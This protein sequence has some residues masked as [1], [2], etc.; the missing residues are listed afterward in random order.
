MQ[1]RTKWR[2]RSF[3]TLGVWTVVLLLQ[4]LLTWP[5]HAAEKADETLAVDQGKEKT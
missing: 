2:C 4:G 3:K 1:T 5:G